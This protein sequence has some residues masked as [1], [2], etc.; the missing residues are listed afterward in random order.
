MEKESKKL[1]GAHLSVVKGIYT[2]QE[3]MDLL[4]SETCAFFVKNQRRYFSSGMKIEDIEKFKKNIKNSEVLLPHGS[5]LINLGN[6]DPDILE[7]SVACLRDD[8]K[9]CNDLSIKYYN[10]HPGSDV[11]KRGIKCLKQI[12]NKINEVIKD[13]PNVIILL[14]N[15][16]GQGTVVGSKFE[17]L[18]EI[19]SN[20]EDKSRIGVCLDTCHLFG[21]G[22]DIRTEEK[23]RKVMNQFDKII[24]LEYLKAMHLND[25]K[26]PL[27]SK[28]DRH[29]CIGKGHIGLEAFKFI[30]NNDIFDNKPLILETPEPEKY[31]EEIKLLKS[32]IEK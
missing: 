31:G 21:A 19:F 5:Y 13:I 11:K 7:K 10:M 22:Y 32:L 20:I 6:P 12:A 25:S 26:E 17:E 14:E 27:G 29:E 2:V 9:R 8:L 3:Q 15:M 24:G 28:K 30:M 23:F 4:G 16:A 1:V 18:K